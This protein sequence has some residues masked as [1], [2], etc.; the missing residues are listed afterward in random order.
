MTQARQSAD[1]VVRHRIDGEMTIYSAA[2]QKARLL[3]WLEAA[4]DIE[5]DLSG[6]EE[7]DSA[8]LQ[9]LLVMKQEAR[10]RDARLHL[11]NHSQAVL[12]VVE[13][14]D[15]QGQLGDPLVL[16]AEWNQS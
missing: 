6:V 7:F 5:L 16:P 3:G 14:L 8:G 4:H 11:V 13:L 9:L 12:E 1:D 2:E 10:Q 15:I